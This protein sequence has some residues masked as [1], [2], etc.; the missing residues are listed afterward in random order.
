MTDVEKL[1]HAF[2]KLAE[3]NAALKARLD[4]MVTEETFVEFIKIVRS[5]FWDIDDAHT[6]LTE[7][8]AGHEVALIE[9]GANPEPVQAVA[10]ELTPPDVADP[11]PSDPEPPSAVPLNEP[12]DLPSPPPASTTDDIDLTH[13]PEYANRDMPPAFIRHMIL[14]KQRDLARTTPPG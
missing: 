3:E 7:V 11:E 8:I 10:Q 6:S 9:M 14:Q 2:R 4:D 1:T 12:A 13:W 5:R